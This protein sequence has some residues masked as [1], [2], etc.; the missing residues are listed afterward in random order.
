[1][2]K[3]TARRK[4]VLCKLAFTDGIQWAERT[5]FRPNPSRMVSEVYP[6]LDGQ[7]ISHVMG[8]MKREG[9]VRCN[10]HL[11]GRP[12]C[13]TPRGVDALLESVS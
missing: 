1:M 2:T 11:R 4:Y 12:L 8:A 6:T 3:L 13:I 5:S 7:D 10:P 9:L